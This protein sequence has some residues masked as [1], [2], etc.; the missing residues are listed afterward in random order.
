MKILEELFFGNIQPDTKFYD[1]D[2]PFVQLAKLRERNRESLL[3]T[4]NENEKD[5]FE[6]FTD[7]QAE[8]DDITRY[9]KFTYGFRLGVALMAEAF[10]GI[11]ELV[12]EQ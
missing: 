8:I 1:K 6:K 5:L 11:G 10:T 7:A 12:D 3:A 2:S 9:Q 4:L